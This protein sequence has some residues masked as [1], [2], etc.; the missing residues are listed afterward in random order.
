MGIAGG[1]EAVLEECVVEGG[2]V[3]ELLERI[4]G[5]A[6]GIGG[7][8]HDGELVDR[9]EREE[10]EEEAGLVFQVT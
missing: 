1:G 6:E 4:G 7:G 3:F 8:G 10:R 5:A 9:E 2:V